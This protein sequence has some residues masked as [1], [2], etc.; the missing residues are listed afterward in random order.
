MNQTFV[1]DV[2]PDGSERGE[3]AAPGA[4]NEPDHPTECIKLPKPPRPGACQRDLMARPYRHGG[5]H[6][7]TDEERQFLDT[8]IQ[9]LE[10]LQPSLEIRG[11]ADARKR[12][13]GAMGVPDP[14][15]SAK[16]HAGTDFE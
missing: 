13:D 3:R 5:V 7:I 9:K 11:G 4:V 6:P 10:S 2:A 16:T 14:A 1:P 8:A 12:L 15:G